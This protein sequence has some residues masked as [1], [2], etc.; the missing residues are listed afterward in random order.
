MEN[1][2][3]REREAIKDLQKCYVCIYVCRCICI[4]LNLLDLKD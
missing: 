2:Y 4:Y 1:P 3:A